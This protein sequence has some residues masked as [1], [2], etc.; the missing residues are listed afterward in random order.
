MTITQERARASSHGVR[1][2]AIIVTP[3]IGLFLCD[4]C[5]YATLDW[6]EAKR[7]DGTWGRVTLDRRQGR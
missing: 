3:G 1:S 4:S 6:N 7:H 5:R 2:H